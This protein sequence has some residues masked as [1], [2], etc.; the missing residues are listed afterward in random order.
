[1]TEHR[2]LW[3]DPG[4]LILLEWS[5]PVLNETPVASLEGS[6][7]ALAAL[8]SEIVTEPDAL[9]DTERLYQIE[10]SVATLLATAVEPATIEVIHLD[11]DCNTV[12]GSLYVEETR[13]V[14]RGRRR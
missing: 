10:R 7:E 13:P 1:M 3:V 6:T 11:H 8:L 9:H 5:R 4:Y 2:A 14:V 12:C